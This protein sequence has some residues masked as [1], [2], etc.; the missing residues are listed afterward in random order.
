MYR[1]IDV[2][3]TLDVRCKLN[4]NIVFSINSECSMTPVWYML[5]FVNLTCVCR[6]CDTSVQMYLTLSVDY[7]YTFIVTNGCDHIFCMLRLKICFV[8]YFYTLLYC[9]AN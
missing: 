3:A 1:Y 9:E 6:T 2:P 8:I 5:C 4:Q 7:R